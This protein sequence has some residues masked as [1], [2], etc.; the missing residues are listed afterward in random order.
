M[1]N[2]PL[3]VSLSLLYFA[4]AS[5]SETARRLG[6][7]QL[8]STFLLHDNPLFQT[9]DLFDRAHQVCSKEDTQE[10]SAE[11]LRM[12]EPFNV[13]GLGDR[14]RRNWYPAGAER[15]ASSFWSKLG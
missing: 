14:R 9:R 6:R 4:A 12:I 11:I 3:F 10:L 1:A 13:A 7:P 8:A 2:F 5:F 15:S